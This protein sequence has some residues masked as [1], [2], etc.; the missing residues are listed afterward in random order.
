MAGF[1]RAG[2]PRRSFSTPGAADELQAWV[3]QEGHL[4]ALTMSYPTLSCLVENSR[5]MRATAPIIGLATCQ[6]SKQATRTGN[7]VNA[8]K[9]GTV[10]TEAEEDRDCEASSSLPISI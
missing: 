4:V 10:G 1:D 9:T 3:R 7:A 5:A 2:I 6:S 8:V